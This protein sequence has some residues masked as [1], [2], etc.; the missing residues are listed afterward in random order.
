M[1]LKNAGSPVVFAAF[2]LALGVAAPASADVAP[3]SNKEPYVVFTVGDSYA[4]GE[5]APE[6]PGNYGDNGH[7]PFSNPRPE[8]W[9]TDFPNFTSGSTPD[10]RGIATERCH[11][12]P[13]STSGVAIGYLE[14]DFPDIAVIFNS[15]A[16]S[17]ASLVAGGRLDRNNPSTGNSNPKPHPGGVLRP[18][19]G[20]DVL[21]DFNPRPDTTVPFPAQLNQI[22]DAPQR[23]QLH[24]LASAS[25]R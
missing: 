1:L 6:V 9:D 20:E 21:Q 2:G 12:S 24:R 7:L 8:D 11:R 19:S 3:P 4:A 22:D 15:V 13:L 25:T 14:A 10:P 23:S 17:G 5:G 18:Y 16:C